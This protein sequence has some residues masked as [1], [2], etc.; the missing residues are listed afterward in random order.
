MADVLNDW[1]S[2]TVCV[3]NWLN[4]WPAKWLPILFMYN[5]YWQTNWLASMLNEWLIDSWTNKWLTN[6][7]T[8]QMT[9][10]LCTEWL[11]LILSVW[12][13]YWLTG[14][15]AD[16]LTLSA[17]WL[18]NELASWLAQLLT[19]S[20]TE[21]LIDWLRLAYCRMSNW[22]DWLSDILK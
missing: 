5:N 22:L 4:G 1:L 7:L 14:W 18:T 12:L 6:W 19:D 8:C 10:L 21:R 11:S 17:D 16:W 9:G 15:L 3:N 20:V 2:F 13:A